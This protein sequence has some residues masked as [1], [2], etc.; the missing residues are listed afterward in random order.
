MPEETK[1]GK[2]IVENG[3]HFLIVGNQRDELPAE[4]FGGAEGLKEMEGQE[5]EVLYS[6][7]SFPVLLRP[8]RRP[9]I[10]CYLVATHWAGHVEPMAVQTAAIPIK[11]RPTCYL[12]A[13]WVIKGV[14]EQVRKNLAGELLA[15]GVITKAVHDKIVG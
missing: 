5:V 9:P 4:L 7:V 8:K 2:I 12:P 14:E 10:L 3:K 1:T 13:P 15:R 6:P 11:I